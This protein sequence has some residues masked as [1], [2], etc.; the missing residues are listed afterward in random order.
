MPLFKN[1][2][3]FT[4]HYG[5]L[6]E[7]LEMASFLKYVDLH[8]TREWGRFYVGHPVPISL[9]VFLSAV[10]IQFTQNELLLCK[11]PKDSFFAFRA[12]A[13]LF[14]TSLIYAWNFQSLV[15]D[16]CFPDVVSCFRER[17]MLFYGHVW[18]VT[19]LVYRS[20]HFHI[21]KHM[22]RIK[23]HSGFVSYVTR[24]RSL[25]SLTYWLILCLLYVNVVTYSAKWQYLCFLR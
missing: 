18:N 3:L 7:M 24:L 6:Q 12:H 15:I 23:W 1:L 11:S 13:V 16:N 10:C 19:C 2:I 17:D 21:L 20:L 22:L 9:C 14:V 25:N 5:N 4:N 8:L